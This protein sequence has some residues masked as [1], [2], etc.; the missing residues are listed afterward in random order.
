MYV[1]INNKLVTRN[2]FQ[3]E[4]IYYI[5]Q[6]YTLEKRPAFLNTH[7]RSFSEAARRGETRATTRSRD[8]PIWFHTVE[9]NSEK[10]ICFLFSYAYTPHICCC[11][12]CCCSSNEKSA[13]SR[14][15]DD[16]VLLL[17]IKYVYIC[18][19]ISNKRI[20]I[21]NMESEMDMHTHYNMY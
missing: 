14:S 10:K 5:I 21:L 1:V 12:C 13:R 2:S 17:L 19:K 9:K 7:T 18:L 6:Q 16:D 11:C 4:P 3:P 8:H 20:H 15:R